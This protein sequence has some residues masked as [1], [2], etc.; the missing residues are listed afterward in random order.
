MLLV[1]VLALRVGENI[2]WDAGKMQAPG[3]PA[4]QPYIEREYRQGWKI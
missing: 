4:A 3:C 2:A 1:G